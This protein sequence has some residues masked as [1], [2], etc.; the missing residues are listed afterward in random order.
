MW[1]QE[2]N[3]V[4]PDNQ[5]LTWLLGA[6]YQYDDVVFPVFEQGGGFPRPNAD[7]T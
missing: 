2:F 7:V 3:I 6:F 1:S 4:S 5:R